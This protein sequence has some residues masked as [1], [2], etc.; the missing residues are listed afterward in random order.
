M[1]LWGIENALSLLNLVTP[2]IQSTPFQGIS[3]GLLVLMYWVLL[4]LMLLLLAALGAGVGGPVGTVGTVD[5]VGVGAVVGAV[6][7][8]AVESDADGVGGVVLGACLARKIG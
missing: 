2:N 4:S 1:I 3:I 8:V 5:T 6:A 7:G